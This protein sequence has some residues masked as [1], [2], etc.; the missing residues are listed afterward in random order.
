MQ[1][2]LDALYENTTY[3]MQGDPVTYQDQRNDDTIEALRTA[4]AQPDPEPV[5]YRSRWRNTEGQIITGWLG[6]LNTAGDQNSRQEIEPLYTA[7][8]QR[9]PLS[10]EEIEAISEA[11]VTNCYFD[12]ITFARAIEAAHGIGG[13]ND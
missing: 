1:M 2:A 11:S 5:A 13:S 7:P 10:D 6:H 4:L 8:P 3:S 9:K 12:T